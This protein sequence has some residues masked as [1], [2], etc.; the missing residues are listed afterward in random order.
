MYPDAPTAQNRASWAQFLRCRSPCVT[1]AAIPSVSPMVPAYSDC[2][3]APSERDVRRDLLLAGGIATIF[4]ALYSA[5]SVLRHMH[6]ETSAFDLGIFDQAIWH[7]SRFEAPAST[8]RGYDNLL[9]DH[10]HPI[11]ALAAPIFWVWNDVRALLVLQSVLLVGSS[12]PV[13]WA[14]RRYFEPVVAAAWMVSYL[15]FWGLL[16]AARFDFHEVAFAVPLIALAC[17]LLLADRDL[18]ALV[19]ILSLLLVKEDLALLVAAFGLVYLLKRRWATGA[20]LLAVGVAAFF[21]ITEVLIPKL[22]NGLDFRYW[23]YSAFGDSPGAAGRTILRRP[24]LLVTEAVNAHDKLSTGFFM[25]APFAFL[26]LLSPLVVLLLP[27]VAERL[28]SDNTNFWGRNFHYTA[29]AA[30]IL[31]IAAI[32]GLRRIRDR[33]GIEPRRLRAVAALLVVLAFLGNYPR[34]AFGDVMRPSQ[35]TLSADE[36]NGRDILNAIPPHAAVIA[37]DALAPHLTHREKI[38]VLPIFRSRRDAGSGI[39]PPFRART[40]DAD[41]VVVNV[42]LPLS[43]HASER[44]LACYLRTLPPGLRLAVSEGPWLVYER[45]VAKRVELSPAARRFFGRF[46]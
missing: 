5:S 45:G 36:R 39:P 21:V 27:L 12:L 7:Y 35:W 44:D 26:S 8:I 25:L 23:S 18:L 41:V 46:G 4:A 14:A 1:R 20:A 30:P 34:L 24:W 29:T 10:F 28:Y 17:A 38:W 40:K 9:G 31:A 11:L 15:L 22:S 43:H 19:P 33:F 13:Y 16:G 3:C 2:A 6:F 42:A 37:Q 32:D